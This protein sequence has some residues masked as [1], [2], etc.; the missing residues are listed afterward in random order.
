MAGIGPDDSG[1]P[2]F[3]DEAA[4]AGLEVA[5][6]ANINQANRIG[7]QAA[8]IR[9]LE[10]QLTELR[11]QRQVDVGHIRPVARADPPS[12]SHLH[13]QPNEATL[14]AG[15]DN[16]GQEITGCVQ[17]HRAPR[18]SHSPTSVFLG[19]I[20]PVGEILGDILINLRD[21]F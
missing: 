20:S 12:P 19:D 18:R 17:A 14:H 13:A 8:Q 3:V 16:V 11:A 9:A 4:G 10:A 1:P 7:W 5:Q 6:R 2:E 15:I 21:V